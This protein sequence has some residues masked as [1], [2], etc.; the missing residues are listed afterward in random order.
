MRPMTLVLLLSLATTATACARSSP[1]G[2]ALDH[3]S[4]QVADEAASVRFYTEVLGLR[5]IPAAYPNRRWFL[6]G[7]GSALHI[8]GGRTG[9]VTGD[10]EFHFA[11]ACSDLEGVMARLRAH[12]ITWY[13]SDDKPGGVSTARRDGVRQIYF[14]DPDGYSIEVNDALKGH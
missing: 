14:R 8:G 3:V 12:G 11:L 13:G 9:P 1:A 7:N 6:L 4:L 2:F 10:D 5:E